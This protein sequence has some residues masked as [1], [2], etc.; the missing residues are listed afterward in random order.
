MTLEGV[1]QSMSWTRMPTRNVHG[2][3]N[4]LTSDPRTVL[5]IVDF[6]ENENA[7][8]MLPFINSVYAMMISR[9][10]RSV[11]ITDPAYRN[12]RSVKL[13]RDSRTYEKVRKVRY[14]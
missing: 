13:D 7:V 9:S 4:V 2:K 14:V 11:Q 8:I 3:H 5:I 1:S 10:K 12:D 6:F